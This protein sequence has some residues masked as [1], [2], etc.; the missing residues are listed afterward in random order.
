V[1]QLLKVAIIASA[2]FP[3]RE[4]FAGGLESH[5]SLL[6]Q[7]LSRRGHSVTV[8]AAPGSDPQS[9]IACEVMQTLALS[10]AAMRDTSMTSEEFMA[11]HHAY[12]RLMLRLS[13]DPTSFDVVHN[14]SLHYLPIAMGPAVATP[15]V[16]TL[17]TP[18]TPWLESAIGAQATETGT[19]AVVSAHTAVAWRHL[20]PDPVV[21]RN[22]VDLGR[23]TP[24]LGGGPLIWAGRIVP[25]KGPHLAI[26]A[27]RLS[28]LP[29]VL[30]GPISDRDYFETQVLPLLGGSVRYLGHLCHDRLADA[31]GAAAAML[32]TPCW[33][34]P[35]GLVVAE[36]LAC[37]TPVAG[38]A[39]GALP[40]LVDASCG[41]LVPAGDVDALA[42]AIPV[43]VGLSRAAARARAEHD[44][45]HERMVDEYVD[46]YRAV[47]S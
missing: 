37:G 9:G 40:E 29:L 7:T 27:A 15:I 16:T 32:V 23:W 47:A 38:F 21:I 2:R 1:G 26:N 25:E 44:W 20:V 5:T 3:I 14:N 46:L 10:P 19:F 17:H 45:T 36:A 39:V 22:G 18:P 4:P 8:F 13:H 30:A 11:E 35:Y 43:V 34:E 28:G 6:A 12:L 41:R 33:N 24:G 42:S 31:V